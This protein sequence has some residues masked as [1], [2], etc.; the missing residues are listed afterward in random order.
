[1]IVALGLATLAAV[2]VGSINRGWRRR[3]SVMAGALIVLE[4]VAIPI[5]T[6]QSSTDYTQAGLAPTTWGNIKA[7][8]GR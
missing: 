4:A 6:N 5:P 8:F 1:M 7:L 3:A 2:G